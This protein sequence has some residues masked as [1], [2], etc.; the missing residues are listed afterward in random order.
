[1]QK[2]IQDKTARTAAAFIG[3]L[4]AALVVGGLFNAILSFVL[5]R[6]GLSGPDRLLGMG[7]GFVRGVF[8]VA[9]MMTV[10]KLTSLP[11][12]QYRSESQ[13]YQHFD[14]MV[15]WLSSH[16][17]DVLQKVK[18]IDKPENII[19]IAPAA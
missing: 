6:T 16:M 3:V 7:F 19:D 12:Q 11:Y 14:P 4:L 18:S 17:P 13:L 1:M 8:I 15:S 9:L 5:K 2:Y 10:I